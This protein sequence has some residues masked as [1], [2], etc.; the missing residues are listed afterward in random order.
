MSIVMNGIFLRPQLVAAVTAFCRD[1]C[2]LCK[3]GNVGY[4]Y[5]FSSWHFKLVTN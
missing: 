4:L 5:L 2:S 3:N 1:F